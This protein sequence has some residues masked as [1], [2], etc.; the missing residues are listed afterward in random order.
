MRQS[1][2]VPVKWIA[3][4]APLALLALRCLPEALGIEASNDNESL[5]KLSLSKLAWSTESTGPRRFISAHGQRAAIFGYPQVDAG[6]GLEVWA[7]PVQ[8]LK[9]YEVTFRQ[10]GATSPIDG[11]AILRRIIY[12]P[13]A[14]TRIYVA[15]S[16][17]NT[18]QRL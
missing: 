11:Q 10:Q 7:Y 9:S 4:G 1:T 12:D 16:R 17:L 14:V 2:K 13:E 8:I 5:S 3:K 15:R 6:D 18:C